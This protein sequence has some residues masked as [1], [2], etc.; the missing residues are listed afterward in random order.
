MSASNCQYGSCDKDPEFICKCSNSASFFCKTHISL[1]T[2]QFRQINHDIQPNI[3]EINPHQKIIFLAQ[4]YIFLENLKKIRYN[5]NQK[6]KEAIGKIMKQ[7]ADD[8]EYIRKT[9]I[10]ITE[11]MKLLLEKEF[12]VKKDQQNKVEKFILRY[13]SSESSFIEEINRK[14]DEMVKEMDFQRKEMA[15]NEMIEKIRNDVKNEIKL[16]INEELGKEIVSKMDEMDR[17]IENIRII[18]ANA[19]DNFGKKVNFLLEEAG[20]MQEN[21]EFFD[22]KM[23]YFDDNTKKLNIIDVASNKDSSSMYNIEENMSMNGSFCR[24]SQ[25]IIF[26]YGGCRG[27]IN[28]DSTYIIDTEQKIAE[29]KPSWKTGGYSGACSLYNNNVYVFGGTNG[30][31]YVTSGKFDIN[32]NAW[33]NIQPLPSATHCNS[34]VVLDNNIFITGYNLGIAYVYSIENNSYLSIGSFQS[35]WNKIICKA[36]RKLYIFENNKLHEFSADNPGQISV[37]NSLTGVP[38][39]FL[40]SFTTRF[41]KDLYFVLSNKNIY[42]F[43]PANKSVSMMRAVT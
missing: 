10:L 25:F 34:T 3:I 32:S 13:L 11:S 38:N 27:G 21:D 2:S 9:E 19:V 41:K 24:V 6:T 1:H 5:V 26:F 7:A 16:E 36:S 22:G 43:N 28:T 20:L 39:N 4:C 15:L 30:P 12:I 40:I 33:Q 37:V 17:K 29:K 35:I 8:M 23:F 14:G 42:R 31:I 18:N